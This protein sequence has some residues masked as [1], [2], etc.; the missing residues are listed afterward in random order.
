V[1]WWQRL[2]GRS[3]LEREL[4]AELRYHFDRLVE[5][6]VRD[7][8][9]R[10]EAVRRARLAFGGVDQVKEGCRDVRGTR[11][12]EDLAGDVRF[13]GRLLRKHRSFTLVAT[14][15]LAVGIGVNGVFLTLVEMICLRGLPI[16]QVDRVMYVATRDARNVDGRVSFQDFEDFRAAARSVTAIGAFAAAPMTISDEAVAAERFSG[17]YVSADALATTRQA[18]LFG[19][20]FRRDDDRTGAP[21]VALIGYR[22]WQARFH[23]DPAVVG[24]NVRI[25]GAP[26]TVVGVMPDGFRFPTHAD[27]WQPLAA[28]PGLTSQRRDERVLG[29]LGR[30]SDGVTAAQASE[31]LDAIAGR[32]AL[33][34]PDTNAG[35]RVTVAPIND[36]YNG[37]VT[38]PAWLAFMTAGGLVLLIACANVANLLL[39]RSAERSREIAIRASLGASRR[40]VIRQLLAESTLIAALGGFAGLGLSI[41]GLRVVSSL[42]PPD[43]LPYWMNFTMNTRLIMVMAL[44]CMGTAILF[45]LL[46]A[47][48]LSVTDVIRALK[49][50]GPTGSGPSRGRPWTTAFVVCQF[51]LAFVLLAQL[52]LSVRLVLAER[53]KDPAIDMTRV[54]TLMVELPDYAYRTPGERLDRLRQLQERLQ[55]LPSVSAAALTT[56]LP[57]GGSTGRQLVLDGAESGS[58]KSGPTV[59]TVIVSPRYFETLGLAIVRGRGF[60][61]RDGSPGHETVIVNQRFAETYLKT[62]TPVGHRIGLRAADDTAAQ[63]YTVI[64]VSPSIRQR[65]VGDPDPVVYV[66][67]REEPPAAVAVMVRGRSEGVPTASDIRSELRALDP[68]APVYRIMTLQQAVNASRWNGRISNVLITTI[69]CIAIALSAVGVYAVVS[70]RVVQRT[71]E[72]GVRVALG[73][74]PRQIALVALR[75]A[76]LPLAA[77]LA[78]GL[79][80]AVAWHKLFASASPAGLLSLS[81]NV[82]LAAGLL[83]AVAVAACVG[84]VRRA[85]RVDPLVAL[86]CE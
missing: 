34:Y 71:R 65:P 23:A 27:V 42:T 8:L 55:Q 29:V 7:G 52:A 59:Q 43:V 37:N 60:L 22:V 21:G 35:I 11:W 26:V 5:D 1:T 38:H 32:L 66:S 9:P 73:A 14:L 6:N 46:P 76:I 44:L 54:L 30:L 63:W 15:V 45:G 50:G 17:V 47:L 81:P 19:R 80:G 53:D 68:D 77:G 13:A 12:I 33:E 61:E 82:L 36:R 69:T 41:G 25:N 48:Q 86:R 3:R 83:V 78:L 4:D 79:A 84:P 64:G 75:W 58:G 70:F 67:L 24:R 74:A 56:A 28:M 31:E 85:A 57:F 2:R 40:R 51:A 72:I 62:R 16:D 18:P 49:D 39:M 10:S 20:G